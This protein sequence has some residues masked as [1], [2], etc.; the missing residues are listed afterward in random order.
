MSSIV[1]VAAVS[2]CLHDLGIE[3]VFTRPVRLGGGTVEA[4]H[5]AMPVPAPGAAALLEGLPVVFG[6]ADAELATPTGVAI[7][8]A[9]ASRDPLPGEV[10]PR[11]VGYGAGTRPSAAL[12]NLLRVFVADLPP[13][14]SERVWQIEVNLDDV[15]PEILGVACDRVREAGAL[16]AYLTPV[17]MKKSGPGVLLTVLVPE[18]SLAAVEARLFEETTTFG[19]RRFP[20]ERTVLERRHTTVKTPWGTVRVKEGLR[21]GSVVTAAPEYDDCLRVAE[22][23]DVALRR[24]YAAAKRAYDER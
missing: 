12:P 3:Q 8:A 16:D 19:L 21:D 20:V 5:G 2:L 6:G 17:Q 11:S 7:L 9:L 18:T 1:D 15:S 23:A 24:V 10:R 13:A 4:A 14:A 22:G